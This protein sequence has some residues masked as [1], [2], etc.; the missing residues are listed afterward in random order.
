MNAKERKQFFIDS[1]P[2]W[3]ETKRTIQSA[4]ILLMHKVLMAWFFQ[5]IIFFLILNQN[6]QESFD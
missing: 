2:I 1:E 4:R 3:I 6:R 5:F